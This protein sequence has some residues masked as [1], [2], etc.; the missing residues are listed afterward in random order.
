MIN[1]AGAPLDN[2]LAM[3]PAN[4]EA[5]HNAFSAL[6]KHVAERDA[7]EH[8]V[9]MIQVENES[10]G[11]GAAR[12]YS[13]ASNREFAGTVPANLVKALHR[14]AGTWSEV[15]PATRMRCSRRGTRLGI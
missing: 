12:D 6:M 8:T 2:F 4:V 14:K 11:I 1:L 5:D 13:P 3:A 10:G 7:T 15:F 9:L